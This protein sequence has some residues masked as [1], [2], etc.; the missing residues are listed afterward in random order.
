MA[1]LE[2]T[3]HISPNLII[4]QLIFD[5]RVHIGEKAYKF[6]RCKNYSK[7]HHLSLNTKKS[8]QMKNLINA[9]KVKKVL[10]LVISIYYTI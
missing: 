2:K 4:H 6:Q 9:V 8:T 5:Q 7:T 10:K 3:I 1:L